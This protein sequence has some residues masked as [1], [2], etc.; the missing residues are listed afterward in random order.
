MNA[1]KGPYRAQMD[2]SGEST[3][4]IV[5]PNS[6]NG[7]ILAV[8]DPDFTREELGESAEDNAKLMASSW[9]MYYKLEQVYV[10]L[11]RL[12][13]GKARLMLQYSLCM[14]RDALAEARGESVE[15]TQEYYE[16]IA[17]VEVKS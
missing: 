2:E 10:E 17:R 6:D 8:V 3:W 7:D 13:I 12:P 11:L 1:T 9:T 16:R 14:C 5:D 4:V 15:T